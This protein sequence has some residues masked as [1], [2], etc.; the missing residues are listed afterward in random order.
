[1][2]CIG[3]GGASALA[4]ANT[5][6]SFE[7]AAD[8]GADVIEFDVRVARGRLLCAHSVLQARWG[9]LELEDALRA[10]AEP[11]FDHIG[12]VADLKTHGT[13]GPVVDGLRRHGLFDRALIT[14]QCRPILERV[15]EHDPAA[16]TG[17][18]VAGRLSRRRQRWRSWRDEV[19]AA[20]RQCG[21]TAVMAHRSLIDAELVERVGTAGA[22]LHAWTA[23]DHADVRA[24][25]QLGVDGVV[26][27]DP[28]LFERPALQLP[29]LG[30]AA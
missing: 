25:G 16:R 15:R 18:S 12:V 8:L 19:V 26:T 1:V 2:K 28:R 10:L 24:L 23:R 6:R 30:L 20:V 13:E 21:Y 9:C 3:H 17:I 14:S 27:A 11:R 7:L 29:A 5:L 22:E 4:P